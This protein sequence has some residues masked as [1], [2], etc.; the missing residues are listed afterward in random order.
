M[1]S[2]FTQIQNFTCGNMYRYAYVQ[3]LVYVH[4]FTS[5]KGLEATAAVTLSYLIPRARP[6][7]LIPCLNKRKQGSKK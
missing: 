7:L 1:N 3:G 2:Y 4:V 5:R 6:W